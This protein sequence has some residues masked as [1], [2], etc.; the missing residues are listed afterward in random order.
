MQL[1][2]NKKFGFLLIRIVAGIALIVGAVILTESAGR[3]MLDKTSLVENIKNL[4]VAIIESFLALQ[5]YIVLYRNA[6]NRPINELQRKDFPKMA[7]AGFA[8]GLLLQALIVTVI[9][10]AGHYSI[11][12][13]NPV[14]YLLPAFSMSLIAGFVGELVIRGIVFRI[15]EEILGTIPTLILMVM[16]FVILHAGAPGASLLSVSVTCI[17]AGLLLSAVYVASRSLWLPIFL[18]FAY[19]FAEP[20]I[21]GG[22]NPG[23]HADKTLFTSMITGNSLISGGVAGPQNSIQGLIFCLLASFIFLR[24]ARKNNQFIRPFWVKM[25]NPNI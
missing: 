2:Y 4:I 17:Q 9:Y 13:I 18:H 15:V 20:G 12:K 16:I 21:F 19:D 24:Y 25:S 23:I 6:E 3:W 5:A 11:E 1:I 10:L 22:I 7:L 14:N 8:I